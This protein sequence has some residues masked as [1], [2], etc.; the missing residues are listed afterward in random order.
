MSVW[1]FWPGSSHL[2]GGG[3]VCPGSVGCS[4]V[5]SVVGDLTVIFSYY[6]TEC[7][8]QHVYLQNQGMYLMFL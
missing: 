1:N 8:F 3:L 6:K 5:K 7:M 2:A 4:V